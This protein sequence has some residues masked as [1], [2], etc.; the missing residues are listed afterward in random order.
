[1]SG[2][3]VGAGELCRPRS[4]LSLFTFVDWENKWRFC[5]HLW[6]SIWSRGETCLSDLSISLIDSFGVKHFAW[7]CNLR[8]KFDP[9][10][11]HSRQTNAQPS[12]NNPRKPLSKPTFYTKQEDSFTPASKRILKWDLTL[13]NPSS[14]KS[15]C[16]FKTW[17][18]CFE[19]ACFDREIHGTAARVQAQQATRGSWR[20]TQQTYTR[21]AQPTWQLRANTNNRQFKKRWRC[22]VTAK[23][24]ARAC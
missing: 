8:P 4:G 21:H 12:P 14:L 18:A 2:C 10:S 19:Q 6:V 5:C 1:M 13:I 23:H 15:S 17:Q 22:G 24:A 16:W 11:R 9:L 7:L 20:C 3:D